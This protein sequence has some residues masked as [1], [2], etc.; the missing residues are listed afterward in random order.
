[1]ATYITEDGNVYYENVPEEKRALFPNEVVF[2]PTDKEKLKYLPELS[3]NDGVFILTQDDDMLSLT[4]YQPDE[5][6]HG[7]VHEE[8]TDVHYCK[9][10]NLVNITLSDNLTA[11][12]WTAYE[13]FSLGTL[14]EGFRPAH[15]SSFVIPTS[16]REL[17][18]RLIVNTNGSMYIYNPGGAVST[19]TTVIAFSATFGIE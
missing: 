12:T 1:M 15:T 6:E 18:L 5:P 3:D 7:T 9:T 19:E 14:P 2:T 16:N 10:G 8:N 17:S 11:R 13:N 4:P